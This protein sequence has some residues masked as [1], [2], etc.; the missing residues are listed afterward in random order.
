MVVQFGTKA[1]TLKCLE[2]QIKTAMVLPQ[3]CFTVQ[4]WTEGRNKILKKIAHQGWAESSLIVR[5]SGLGEDNKQVSLAGHFMTLLDV[6]GKKALASAVD[7]VVHSFGSS[8]T[9]QDQVFIQPMLKKVVMSGVAFTRDPSNGG[10]YFIINYDDKSGSTTTVTSGRSNNLK[11][12]YHDKFSKIDKTHRLA[13]VIALLNE[14]EMLFQH[15]AIDIEFVICYDGTEQEQLFLLQCRP[16]ILSIKSA[17]SSKQHS[18][19]LSQ[20]SSKVSSLNQH[21]PYLFGNRT[22]FGVMPDWNPAEIIGV[23]P[24]PLA[25][26]LYKDMVTDSIWAYQRDNYGYRNLRSFPLLVNLAGFPYID[27][28]VS[29]NSFIPADIHHD[30]AERLVN[31]YMDLLLNSPGKHDKI[32]F[33]IIFSCYTLDLPERLQSLIPYGFSQNDCDIIADSLRKLT[34]RIIH[35]ESGLWVKDI[36][37][38]AELKRRQI[39]IHDSQLGIIAKMYWLIEDCKRYGTLPFAGLARAGFIAV[40]ILKSLVFVG[41]LTNKDYDSFMSSLNTVGSQ[42][43]TDL[44]RLD[45]EAF[46]TKYGHLRPGTYDILSH[47]YDESPDRYFNWTQTTKTDAAKHNHEFSLSLEKLNV[48][49]GLLKEHELNHNVLSL[50]SFIKAA[51]EGREYAK[52]VFT[53]SLSDTLSLILQLAEQMN[54]SRDDIS[55]VDIN[56]IKH[57]YSSSDDLHEVLLRAIEEGK[58]KY[59]ITKSLVLPPLIT[60]HDDVFSFELPVNE[61]NFITLKSITSSVVLKSANHEQLYGQILMIPSADPGYDWIFSHNVGGF[62]TM[63]GGVNSHMAIR[64]AEMGV[65]AVIGAGETLYKRWAMATLLE[66]DCA[67]KQVRVLS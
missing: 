60:S 19:V 27:S 43:S 1:D 34:N 18:D 20:I 42:I 5:S 58:R 67:N 49:E 9:G 32:E 35:G 12:Y 29:F 23:R 64:A 22:L 50:F 55:Y 31:H 53:K 26:S 56:I 8:S 30:L 41:I 39:C 40:Q 59:A 47:R 37:K 21:H 52:F 48:L 11:T 6:C 62:I 63:Y 3:V 36:D 17:L 65:P 14:L 51:I 61:P 38:I 46:L 54:I 2:N 44:E 13:K 4:T 7:Q 24:F 25:L 33:E 15:D 16:L 57:L 45:K 66:L 28:R 10:Y